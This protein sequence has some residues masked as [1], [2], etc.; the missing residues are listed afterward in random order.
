MSIDAG[1][2]GSRET[3]LGR[4][5]LNA[6]FR[7]DVLDQGDLPAGRA[8]L[9]GDDGRVGEEKLPDL[10]CGQLSS[11][12]RYHGDTYAEPLLAVLG[13]DVLLVG[14]PVSVPMPNS[15]RVV[16]A[17]GI[18]VLDLK[19]SAL[20]LVDDKSERG[21]GVGTGEDVL[22][23][24][25]TPDEILVLPRLAQTSHL[26]EESTVVVEHVV[27]LGEESGKVADTNVLGHFET[28]DGV[29]TTRNRGGI[30]IVTAHDAALRF[31]NASLAEPI[32]APGGLVASKSDTSGMS[33]IVNTGELGKSAPSAAKIEDLVTGLDVD[34]FTDDGEFVVLHLFKGFL[35]VD[36]A[37]DTGRVDHAGAKE[38]GVKVVTTV[39]MSTDLLLI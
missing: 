12:H 4:N 14:H 35:L 33:A 32:V 30:T 23:H 28:R 16:H 37:D 31:F 27:D 13:L 18:N 26:K 36:V 7:V 38:P 25:Q 5:A 3:I 20:E 10:D 17:N 8:A 39:I 34:L 21:T 1:L 19:A 9:A 11:K 15:S 2:S 6:V 22:V 24:E 29:V